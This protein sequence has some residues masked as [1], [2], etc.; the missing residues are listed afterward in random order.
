M[1]TQL[2]NNEDPTR[3]EL[4]KM[5]NKMKLEYHIK[6]DIDGLLN[7]YFIVKPESKK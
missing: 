2:H 4:T 6:S 5:F 3:L 7:V 1:A